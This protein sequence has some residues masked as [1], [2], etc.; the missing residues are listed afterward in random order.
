MKPLV[1]VGD[2]LLD[3]DVTGQVSR[4]SPDAPVPVFDEGEGRDRP[5]GAGLT[6]ALAAA[7]GRAVVLVTAIGGDGA[8]SR[9]RQLL[10]QAGVRVLELPYRGDTPQ[11]IRLQAG[12]QVVLRL[13]RGTAPGRPGAPG[14][15]VLAA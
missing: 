6:A 12:T 15:D 13:D 14:P 3:R 8:G 11:K 5:G 2:A 7:D 4:I 9:L 10:A 1:V